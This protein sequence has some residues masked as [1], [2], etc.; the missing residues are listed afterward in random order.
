MVENQGRT[1]LAKRGLARCALLR[2]A[3]LTGRPHR[4]R[5]LPGTR[6]SAKPC[7]AGAQCGCDTCTDPRG[8][9]RAIET[10]QAVRFGCLTRVMHLLLTRSFCT[11]WHG[12]SSPRCVRNCGSCGTGCS[13]SPHGYAASTQWWTA[14]TWSISLLEAASTSSLRF[15]PLNSSAQLKPATKQQPHAMPQKQHWEQLTKRVAY[16]DFLSCK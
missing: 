9:R 1:S 10:C 2:G 12:G 15:A 4:R 16:P 8:G 14:S 13:T 11:A 6:P 5:Q 7:A 3:P